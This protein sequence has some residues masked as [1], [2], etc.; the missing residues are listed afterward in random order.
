MTFNSF[1]YALFLPAVVLLY[2]RLGH[3]AQNRLL[4]VASYVFYGAWDYRF[5][6]LLILSTF[7]DFHVGKRLA[8]ATERRER[9][10]WLYVSLAVNLGILGFFKY[11]NFFV[12]SG[13]ALLGNLGL[14]ATAP[15][16]RVLLPI[17]V[18]FYTF[19]ELSYTIDVWRGKRTAVPSLVDFAVYVAYFPHLVA[20]PIQRAH[21][22]LPQVEQARAWPGWE[23]IRSGLF[24]ILLGLFRK[25]VIADGLAPFVR[26]AF[27]GSGTASAITLLVGVWAFALEIYGD[28]AGYTD[29][30]RGSSRLMGIELMH[31]FRQPYLSR[32]VTAFWRTWH[33]SLS[34]WLRDYLYVPLG[35]N[36]AGKLLTYRNLMLTMLIGGLW[37]GAAWTFVVWGGLHGIY[38][39]AHKMMGGRAEL[40]EA[41]RFRARDIVPAFVT[42]NLVCLTWIFFRAQDFTQA[43]EVLRGILTLR[44]G[45]YDLDGIATLLFASIATLTIDVVQR[46]GF[47]PDLAFMRWPRPARG[48]LY[49]ALGTA[50]LV[51]SGATSVPFIYFQF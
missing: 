17:G 24:L 23:R 30:A 3:R 41:P 19:Q 16:L 1:A 6:S 26:Q 49:G 51:F 27:D 2:W 46:N 32:N 13:A 44:G 35:G 21:G 22:L 48:A 31:N 29:I 38:L 4:L 40:D 20:G 34:T 47:D 8:I 50:V 18:S 14:E 45:T 25:V 42:F 36:R 7:V 11:F 33:I 43:F 37:H 15:T 5:L 39:A 28:F 12:D 9:N 10:R